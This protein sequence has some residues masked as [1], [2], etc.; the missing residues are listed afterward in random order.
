MA[1]RGLD[2]LAD[3]LVELL[4][5]CGAPEPG[6][7]GGRWLARECRRE[8]AALLGRAERWYCSLDP[9]DRGWV[10]AEVRRRALAP[11]P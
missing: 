5:Y 7:S 9:G 4:G 10:R 11:R 3:C 6:G 2:L 1:E 8:A